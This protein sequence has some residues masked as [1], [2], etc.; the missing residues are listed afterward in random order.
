LFAVLLAAPPALAVNAQLEDAAKKALKKAEGDYLGMNYGAGIARLKK[1]AAACGEKGCTPGTRAALVC[2]LATMLFRKGDKAGASKSW[3]IAAKLKADVT[4]NPAYEQPDLTAAFIEATVGAPPAGDFSHTPPAEQKVDLPLPLYFEG[5]SKEATRVVVFYRTGSFGDWKSVELTK[6]GSG[7]GGEIPCG[8]IKAGFL[9]YYVQAFNQRKWPVGGTGDGQHPFVVPIRS[10]ITAPP[11]HLPGKPAPESCAAGGD[12]S[13]GQAGGTTKSG[14]GEKSASEGGEGENEEGEGARPHKT[15]EKPGHTR[16]EGPFRHWWIGAAFGIEFTFLPSGNDL[17]HLDQATA[18]PTDPNHM[19]CT[20]L[21][22]A[23]FPS[24]DMAGYQLNGMIVPGE[25]G[26]S[27]GGLQRANARIMLSADYA[28]TRNLLLGARVGYVLFAYDG[29]AAVADGRTS[30]YG[31]LHAEARATW[32]FGENPLGS[33]GLAPM[34][35]AGGGISHFDAN[36]SSSV[37]LNNGMTGG[38]NIWKVDGP[39]FGMAGGGI[40]W[41]PIAQVG[42]TLAARANLAFGNGPMWTFGPELGVAYG[43]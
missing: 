41:A 10:E 42:V 19:Y 3:K 14:P 36:T 1:A 30:P 5:G 7:W 28:V 9:R 31:R 40:R 23:D 8:A 20:A 13:K 6:M 2:D 18:V 38:V 35:F 33:P 25:A 15:E 11:P 24:R 4:L 22:G 27:G 21:N 34:V 39:W 32:V 17:C 16:D 43:F 37:T 12:A 29:Q 26:Q